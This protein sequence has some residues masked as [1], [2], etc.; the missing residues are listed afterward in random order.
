MLDLFQKIT[1]LE[2]DNKDLNKILWE[3]NMVLD[4]GDT[5]TR[6]T[7][8]NMLEKLDKHFVKTGIQK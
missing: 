6:L 4:H 3:A 8:L 5:E 2:E 1:E 7:R